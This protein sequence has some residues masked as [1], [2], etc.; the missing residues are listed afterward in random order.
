MNCLSQVAD[1]REEDGDQEPIPLVPLTEDQENAMEDKT[2]QGL[3]KKCGVSAP[4][5][6]QVSLNFTTLKR[7]KSQHLQV[8]FQSRAHPSVKVNSN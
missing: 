6:E 7:V 4:A 8:C 2:F 1:D 3:L 5:N